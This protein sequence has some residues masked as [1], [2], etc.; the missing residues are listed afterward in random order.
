MNVS[1]GQRIPTAI[2]NVLDT[3]ENKYV[4]ALVCELDCRDKSDIDRIAAIDGDWVHK[5][6]IELNMKSKY[7]DIRRGKENDTRIYTLEN[8]DGEILGMTCVDDL[9]K[10][11]EVR[12]IESRSDHRY[13]YV[14]QNLLASLGQRVLNSRQNRLIICSAVSSA[15]DFYEK[16]CGF[17][18]IGY[19]N[20]EMNRMDLHRFIRRT[21]EKTQKSM[22][23]LRA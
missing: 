7:S 17:K 8:A 22:V 11:V 15:F 20:L 19:S 9:E 6:T 21:E 16:V 3:K 4:P 23:N 14:G 1:F 18:D 13:K 2:C 12:F 10:N 5:D